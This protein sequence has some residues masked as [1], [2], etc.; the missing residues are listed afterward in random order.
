[1]GSERVGGSRRGVIIT[2]KTDD[3]KEMNLLAKRQFI[4]I[5]SVYRPSMKSKKAPRSPCL[6]L[7]VCWLVMVTYWHSAQC[8]QMLCSVSGCLSDPQILSPASSIMVTSQDYGPRNLVLDPGVSNSEIA[9]TH[10]ISIAWVLN[11][12]IRVV[13]RQHQNENK[14]FLAPL[15]SIWS[16]PTFAWRTQNGESEGGKSFVME[17]QTWQTERQWQHLSSANCW[18]GHTSR[19]GRMAEEDDERLRGDGK[20]LPTIILQQLWHHLYLSLAT[21]L[22]ACEKLFFCLLCYYFF[23]C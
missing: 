9:N 18:A 4:M 7:L 5:W 6:S 20:T 12:E 15:S 14:K 17:P 3:F 23:I 2:P 21:R 19:E 22:T 13:A 8:D 11:S 1:M 16:E 10:S